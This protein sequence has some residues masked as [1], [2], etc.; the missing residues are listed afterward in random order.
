MTFI[1]LAS[2][3]KQHFIQQS[4]IHFHNVLIENKR[5]CRLDSY[6]KTQQGKSKMVPTIMKHPHIVNWRQISIFRRK[7]SVVVK[8]W[9]PQTKTNSRRRAVVGQK[10]SH[11][12]FRYE[13]G[14]QGMIFY[15]EGREYTIKQ[16][17]SVSLDHTI[18]K[19]LPTNR[20]HF[21]FLF[22]KDN[23]LMNRKKANS[24]FQYSLRSAERSIRIFC[25]PPLSPCWCF[26]GDCS[27]SKKFINR[28]KVS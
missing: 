7:R 19:N 12:I 3:R 26:S 16:A 23:D 10:A 25:L 27:S 13:R 5:D 1:E 14:L 9:K 20:R 4:H 17:R 28:T 11:Q 8:Q 6:D 18:G 22:R 24:D 21:V 15:L 2:L